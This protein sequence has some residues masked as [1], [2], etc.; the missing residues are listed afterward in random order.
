LPVQ[1][2]QSWSNNQQMQ[3]TQF[4]D[5]D[6]SKMQSTSDFAARP[7]GTSLP[8]NLRERQT[9]RPVERIPQESNTVVVQQTTERKTIETMPTQHSASWQT[10]Q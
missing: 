9:S 10:R 3:K 8:Q 1:N 6:E 7:A 5:A 4:T 2:S